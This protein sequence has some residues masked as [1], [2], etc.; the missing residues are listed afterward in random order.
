MIGNWFGGTLSLGILSVAV[1][2]SN[3]LED[4]D[5][6]DR[7]VFVIDAR[8]GEMLARRFHD[9]WLTKEQIAEEAKEALEHEYAMKGMAG[10]VV[11]K[12]RAFF[13]AEDAQ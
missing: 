7:G 2:D 8:S 3:E 4:V 11:A 6:G 9:A 1:G 5:L 12:S 10:E 13:E